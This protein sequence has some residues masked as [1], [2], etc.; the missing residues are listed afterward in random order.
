MII[1]GNA[2]VSEEIF[3]ER[4]V[5]DLNACKGACCVEGSSG[6]PL[7]E[8]ELPMLREAFHAVKP[9]LSEDG[10]AAIE[11]RGLYETDED[12]DIVTPLIGHQGACAYVMY[13]ADGTAKCAFER[14]Y[15]DGKTSW[16]KPLS[17][18]LYPIRLT[19][20]RDYV[21]VNYHRWPICAPACEC[22][23][24]LNVPVFR[25]LR[26]PLIRKFGEEWY[27]ELETIYEFRK[28]AGEQPL[29]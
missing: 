20:L 5:C 7:S 27:Q 15:L 8:D 19:Q 16:K 24:R 21:G 6:A 10:L 18:H 3:D 17:C 11:A 22:G 2:L 9:M 13:D 4:F 29:S 14:A 28:S 1:V 23:T 12:G 25:F 26:E